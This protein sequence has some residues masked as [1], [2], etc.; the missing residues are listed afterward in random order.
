M[1]TKNLRLIVYKDHPEV[2]KGIYLHVFH[3]KRSIYEQRKSG[4]HIIESNSIVL[5]LGKFI[6]GLDGRINGYR[7]TWKYLD[8]EELC[9]PKS[10]KSYLIAD[11]SAFNNHY[12]S[13][14][15]ATGRFL[16]D[17][18]FDQ[19]KRYEKGSKSEYRKVKEGVDVDELIIENLTD[20]LHQQIQHDLKL[21]INRLFL[22]N[23]DHEHLKFYNP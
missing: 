3:P 10:V 12:V 8:T 1:T 6:N 9:F 14:M 23:P 16:V 2:L 22:N 19:P 18:L 13:R 21:Q 15:E 5:K 4:K 20:L 11:L 17:L 7:K